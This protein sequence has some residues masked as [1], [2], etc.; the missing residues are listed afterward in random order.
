MKVQSARG[1]PWID[2]PPH[3]SRLFCTHTIVALATGMAV[4]LPGDGSSTL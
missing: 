3:S 4:A 1:L 2:V